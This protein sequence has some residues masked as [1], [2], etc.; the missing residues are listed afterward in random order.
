MK[1][2]KKI[3]TN[4]LTRTKKLP[5]LYIQPILDAKSN[6]NNF[7]ESP[8]QTVI[9]CLIA[10]TLALTVVMFAISWAMFAFNGGY[11]PIIHYIETQGL[12]GVFTGGYS[13]IS[14][15]FTTNTFAIF[16]GEIPTVLF[17]LLFGLSLFGLY[18]VYFIKSD[19]KGK[20]AITAL[21]A[22]LV[23]TILSLVITPLI[24]LADTAILLSAELLYTAIEHTTI[25]V[26]II[27]VLVH[28]AL[29]A[30]S[31]IASTIILL[32]SED[33][34]KLLKR[35]FL[36]LFRVLVVA[37]ILLWF[38]MNFVVIVALIGIIAFSLVLIGIAIAV[39][40]AVFSY[41]GEGGGN[42]GGS[43]SYDWDDYLHYC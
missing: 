22:L 9:I 24:L 27:W 32:F 35:W 17:R 8:V 30:I 10:A 4:I 25:S 37:P 11:A 21:F 39:L 40:V 23:L 14:N 20:I 26:T 15:Y 19:K 28:F 7:K 31:V 5:I 33:V 1:I 42:V 29:L 43:Q 12:W 6:L 3:N 18:F 41:K 13:A 36:A 2:N 16:F 38:V 34:R